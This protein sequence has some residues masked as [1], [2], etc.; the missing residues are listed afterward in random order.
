MADVAETGLRRKICWWTSANFLPE[1]DTLICQASSWVWRFNGRDRE[2]NRSK[3]AEYRYRISPVR[4][5]NFPS[6]VGTTFEKSA[7]VGRSKDLISLP[8]LASSNFIWR[9]KLPEPPLASRNASLAAPLDRFT[10]YTSTL[11]GE[12]KITPWCRV[13]RKLMV[14]SKAWSPYFSV[15]LI[16]QVGTGA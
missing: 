4:T 12:I 2:T 5:I 16:F 11:S 14:R 6:C 13:Q 1:G 3:F 8:S 10:W 7:L 15:M 9:M